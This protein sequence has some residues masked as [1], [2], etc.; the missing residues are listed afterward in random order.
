M[1]ESIQADITGHASRFLLGTS[2]YTKGNAKKVDSGSW[3]YR[4]A[5]NWL[6]FVGMGILCVGFCFGWLSMRH[7]LVRYKEVIWMRIILAIGH[8]VLAA[9]GGI[10]GG[11]NDFSNRS[12]LS[13]LT[14][15]AG[16]SSWLSSTS[17]TC[18]TSSM[19]TEL[20]VC[21]LRS[22]SSGRICSAP[23][24]TTSRS[25]TSTTSCKSELS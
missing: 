25:L 10:G 17:S 23:S 15:C 20:S 5:E 6:F 4:P 21:T 18:A 1:F 9:W 2:Q 3:P 16:T 7:R 13:T 24:I 11:R 12:D 19:L 14:T 8:F 22:I